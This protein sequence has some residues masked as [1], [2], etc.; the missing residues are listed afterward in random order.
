MS[1]ATSA[2]TTSRAMTLAQR[3]RAVL[4]R[5]G[6]LSSRRIAQKPANMT[7][8]VI[9]FTVLTLVAFGLVMVMSSS[10]IVALNRGL[11]P[12]KMFFKQLMWA[13][14]GGL[15]MAFLFR[16]PY[17]M[18]RS[19]VFPV[20]VGAYALMFL[21]FVPNIGVSTNGA[22]AWV[23]FG[24]VGFQPSE[25]LKLA[26]LVYCAN[27]LGRRQKEVA[28]FN[29]TT[30]PVMVALIISVLLCLMQRDLGGA[31]VMTCIVLTVMCLAGIPMRIVNSIA[32]SAVL[33]ALFLTLVT[34]SRRN[35]W[36]AFLN[37][38]ETKGSFG[39]QVWQSILSISNGG[40]SGVGVGAGT[41]KWGYVPL[42]HS[43]FIFST[44]AEEMG[45]IGVTVVIGGF[46]TLVVAGLRAALGAEERFGALLAGGITMWFA[47]QAIINI[48]GV[49]G[50]MPVTGLTLPLISYGGSSL[51][52]CMSAAGLLMN[53]ARN[54]K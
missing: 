7:F 50:S 33:A 12:W 14:F 24:P 1:T 48:G 10:S 41:G 47:L 18:L 26:L 20:L 37:L 21:P 54:M 23:A 3:R 5:G 40:I 30:R 17:S 22:R 39:Y 35:R 43:D 19:F 51:L 11:S 28:D 31:I 29:R 49:T 46:L 36:T 38:D 45:L 34:S 42:A 32:G 4:D 16:F 8:F 27:L 44:I 25:F 13:C 9:F 15:G 52:V 6:L 53:V 2:P